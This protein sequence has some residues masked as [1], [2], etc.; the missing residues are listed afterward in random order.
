M[1]ALLSR[2]T[3]ILMKTKNDREKYL[4]L[5]IHSHSHSPGVEKVFFFCLV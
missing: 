1:K 3:K 2:N 5:S 4:G